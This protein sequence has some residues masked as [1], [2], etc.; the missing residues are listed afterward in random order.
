MDATAD[1][2]TGGTALI[3]VP[4]VGDDAAGD[5][6]A[7]MTKA[8][9][10]EFGPGAYST[11]LTQ[12]IVVPPLPGSHDH[13]VVHD[14]SCARVHRSDTAPPLVVYEMHW[15]DLSRFPGTLRKFVLTLYGVLFQISTIG[16]EAFRAVPSLKL[17][18]SVI[19][20]FSYLTAVLVVGLTAGATILGVEFAAMVRLTGHR[21]RLAIA[22]VTL[23]LVAALAWYGDS[24]LRGHGWRFSS[25]PFTRP[26]VAF[27]AVALAVGV[28]PLL[29]YGHDTKGTTLLLA[30]HDVLWQG[31]RWVLPVTWILVGIAAVAI[32]LLML[33]VNPDVPPATDAGRSYRAHRTAVLSV[34]VGGLGIALLGAVLVAA[35]LAATAQAAGVKSHVACR[36]ARD[37]AAEKCIFG[38]YAQSLFTRSLRPLSVA[39]L[40]A[41]A[42]LVVILIAAFRYVSALMQASMDK[43]EPPPRD[44]VVAVAMSVVLLAVLVAAFLWATPAVAA[45]AAIVLGAV[46]VVLVVLHWT[47]CFRPSRIARPFGRGFDVLLAYLGSFWHVLLLTFALLTASTALAMGT[48]VTSGAGEGLQSLSESF[49]TPLTSLAGGS[50]LGNGVKVSA[51]VAVLLALAALITRNLSVLAKALDVAYDVATYVRIPH[52]T[53]GEDPVEP[54]RRK[55]LRRYATLLDH[56]QAVQKPRTIVI[57]AHSQGS[58]YT[59]ALLFGDEFRDRADRQ[60]ANGWPLAPRALPDRPEVDR[61]PPPAVSTRLALLTAGCPIRQTYAPNFP[62][63]YDWPADKG[64][65]SRM[66]GDIGP[67]TTWRNVYRSGDYLGRGLWLGATCR[68]HAPWGALT[69]AC[70]GP[71][72]HTGYWGDR[73][74]ARHVV[75]LI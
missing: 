62:G 58:M 51:T 19:R 67:E 7:S 50:A 72:Q 46:A 35:G 64:V 31:V 39:L 32:A 68:H 24:F 44:D 47:R 13:A 33:A 28:G 37:V 70:L 4:G 1:I 74:F 30:V 16:I 27:G 56:V 17:P 65:V 20:A 34:V 12:S 59:L 5:T 3:V 22:G 61:E 41:L 75:A 53:P 40:C 18:I 8:L 25:T 60:E 9:L 49:F 14:V 73:H 21:E 29:V 11:S 2:P 26:G 45:V 55:I 66:L 38:D 15:A 48:P 57:A 23:L 42:L 43:G 63:Q 71:G 54:P 10:V 36:A 6:V 52:G 69:E